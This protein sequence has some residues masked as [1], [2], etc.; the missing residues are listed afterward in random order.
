MTNEQ[1]ILAARF[2]NGI[3]ED[4]HTFAHW[5]TLGYQVRKGEHAAFKT[6]IWKYKKGKNADADANEDGEKAEPGRMFL[7][8]AFFFTRSQV[9]PIATEA[10]R[11]AETTSQILEATLPA[12]A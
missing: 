2:L 6:A 12:T 9:D 11:Q 5:K 4:A 1:I 3:T 10:A 8:T 7:K